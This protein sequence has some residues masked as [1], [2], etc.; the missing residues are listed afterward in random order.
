MD[1]LIASRKR[2]C[3]D[4]RNAEWEEHLSSPERLE[5]KEIAFIRAHRPGLV[6]AL[7]SHFER[8]RDKCGCRTAAHEQADCPVGLIERLLRDDEAV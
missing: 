7:W 3:D 1:Q 5:P 6:A 2:L 8:T 4:A